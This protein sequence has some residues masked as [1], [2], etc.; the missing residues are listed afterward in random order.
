MNSRHP[1]LD[2]QHQRNFRYELSTLEVETCWS[3]DVVDLVADNVKKALSGANTHGIG[4]GLAGTSPVDA[5]AIQ[6][7][8]LRHG[9]QQQNVQWE[10]IEASIRY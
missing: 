8:T 4:R 3:R 2:I 10:Q 6:G 7:L 9:A 5:K 1:T